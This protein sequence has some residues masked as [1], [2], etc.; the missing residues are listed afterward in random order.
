MPDTPQD[1][2]ASAPDSATNT[3]AGAHIDRIQQQLRTST[4]Q[5]PR[6]GLL[7]TLSP[8]TTYPE[9]YLK[10]RKIDRDEMKD[11]FGRRWLFQRNVDDL[12]AGLRGIKEFAEPL[13]LKALKAQLQVDLDVRSAELRLYV[14]SR[15]IFGIDR[16]ADHV[17]HMTLL[18]AA[19]H[20][21]DAAETEPTAFSEGSGVFTRDAEGAAQRHSMTVA[22]FVGLCRTLDLGAMY[23]AH[24][25]SVLTPLS[26]ARRATLQQ[27]TIARDKQ[28]FKLAALTGLLKGEISDH[29]YGLLLKVAEEAPGG[30]LYG[31]PVH[32][33]RLTLMGFRLQG[34]TLFSAIGEPGWAKNAVDRLSTPILRAV[35][36]WSNKI[37]FLPHQDLERF[38]LLQAFFANGPHGLSEAMARN[39]DHYQQSRPV[40]PLIVY[41]PDDPEHPLREY[42]S[43]TDFM[44]NLIGQLR[45]S[46][47][48]AFFSRFVAQRDKGT[49]FARVNERLK[50]FTWQHRE[51]LD[52][53]PWWRE[54]AT[55][56]PNPEPLTHI[57]RGDL[58][59]TLYNER[60]GKAISDA[61]KIAVP[62]GDEDARSRW[63][64]LTGYL[65]IAWNVFN[66]TAMLVPGLAE[67]MLAVMVAQLLE[68]LAEGL[69]DWSKGDREEAAAHISSVLINGAQLA[70]MGAGHVLPGATPVPI[71]ASPFFD[72][73]KEVQ[74]PDG[75]ASLWK[76]DL[77][78]YERPLP[79]RRDAKADAW[80]L[81]RQ[82][83]QSLVVLENKGYAVGQDPA[84]GQHRI[85]HPART[86]AYQPV[87]RHNGLGGWV[88][89][90]E[91]PLAWDESQVWRRVGHSIEQLSTQRQA[92][93]RI[94][95]GVDH[96]QLR[97]MHVEHEPPPGVLSDTLKRF[98]V[99]ADVE[100][101]SQQI[102]D[103][104]VG[105]SAEGFMPGFITELP[106]WP[107]SR[108]L[109]VFDHD[110]YTGA[111][112]QY[113]SLD[114]PEAS[115][116]KLSRGQ[117]H[118]GQWAER[119]LDALSEEEILGLLGQRVSSVRAERL[120]VLRARLAM[121]A[122]RQT[123]RVFNSIYRPTAAVSDRR[124]LLLQGDFPQ[125]PDP[126]AEQI[127]RQASPEDLAF[128]D[129]KSRVPLRLKAQA[130]E[131][132]HE[133]RVARAYEGLY[134]DALAGADT[135]RLAL[136]SVAALPGWSASVRIE[137]RE[138]SF[139]GSLRDS[140]GPAEAAIRRVLV[141]ND[142]GTFEA[143]D[144]LDQHLHGADD[145]Y[146]A[147]LH[148]L[149]D[150]ER[151]ALG[152][153]IA[154]KAQLK[155][156]V[157][158]QPLERSRFSGLLQDASIRKPA[159]D[160]QRIKLRGGMPFYR[161]S[162]GEANLRMRIQ[163]LYPAFENADID[164]VL[165]DL[166]RQNIPMENYVSSLEQEFSQLCKT[167][168]RWRDASP[169]ALRFSLPGIEQWQARDQFGTLL[170][171]CWQRTGPR[172]IEVPGQAHPQALIFDGLPLDRLLSNFPRLEANF[173][174]VTSL[175]MR[176]TGVISQHMRMLKLF[177]RLR[178]LDLANNLLTELPPQLSGM[179][180]LNDL[181]LQGNHITLVQESID[182]LRTLRHLHSLSLAGNPIG[183]VPDISLM[184]RLDVLVLTNT[185]IET[186]PLGLFS[187]PRPRNF[188]LDLRNNPISVV[189][190]VEP[191]SAQAE[192]L[193]RTH[194]T[195]Q[196][197]PMSAA[198]IERVREYTVS[199]GLDPDRAFPPLGTVESV[200]WTEGM[201]E[202]QWQ[203]LQPVWDDLEDEF[204]SEP[205]FS[206]LGDLRETADFRSGGAYREDLT[207]KVW[208]ML[209][210][211][212]ENSELRESLFA[213]ATVPTQCRDGSIQAFNEL[214][215]RVLVHEARSLVN[216][217]LVEAEL[218]ELAKG[219]SRIEQV[220]KI[221]RRH[222]ADRLAA[223]ERLRATDA[224]GNVTGTIDVVEVHLAFL[225]ALADSLDL[226]WQARSMLFRNIAGVT[227]QMIDDAYDTVL[228]LEQAPLLRQSIIDVPFW[229]DY[230]EASH[231][232]SFK[233]LRKRY[234]D[235]IA[236]KIA[237]D[238]RA[239]GRDLTPEA[240][241][242]LKEE[243]RVLAFE[244]GKPE[245]TIAPGLIM[246]EED[247]VAELAGV[248]AQINGLR[249]TLTQQAMDRAKIERVEMPFTVAAAP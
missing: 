207:N 25:N 78:P 160:P 136:H 108:A 213:E 142:N 62:T 24:I 33:Q 227:Q 124:Q 162:P 233:D 173:D 156:R 159:Y 219:Q 118:T 169:D 152:F 245:S 67:A 138:L 76:P 195:R 189:P 210:A 193:A 65:D 212:H 182:R 102:L 32:Q 125:L 35:L 22:Q 73:L 56:N 55:E 239:E 53:G 172:G 120:Q 241:D 246:S 214:G 13:L 117:L 96:N 126:F 232:R 131:A 135:E 243:L 94:V 130:R 244:L 40:G 164:R 178:F 16:G 154:H 194:L 134:L 201:S 170:R 23:Q 37:P 191:G 30:T 237:L 234:T 47:Y 140:V 68:E 175:R 176:H 97:R 137:V 63:K 171:R 249:E 149:P 123:E 181:A 29:G 54:T 92:Q 216:P 146:G 199:V 11:L 177:R 98:R 226:P 90:V 248:E 183:R 218:V 100:T 74:L 51:P 17:R 70:M 44:K 217:G 115:I 26:A 151:S 4:W 187:V 21:F 71:K 60:R 203:Q 205:F 122:G 107:E 127:L 198:A 8:I 1:K 128:V 79:L 200:H 12:T 165:D 106:R 41:I 103:N 206:L 231:R 110:S 197:P 163:S 143:R 225:V 133:V 86:N 141:L 15:I 166:Y 28:A 58:W 155:A 6:D 66:F 101:L 168:Q 89:E 157:Q 223:G 20:N 211:M 240:R 236:F 81:H 87:L 36:D 209:K 174:H 52:M 139:N 242:K 14:P 230:I 150:Q 105:E 43:F 18:D 72:S 50:T 208:R 179:P 119:V 34:I 145:V 38:K 184:S 112:I 222:V 82:D 148:A 220:N 192:L 49:F 196:E 88:S 221:A 158:Q 64:R 42:D 9:W 75:S 229:R 113:G 10:A 95:S 111:S 57:I 45:D 46:Q 19:L 3:S 99:Y 85:Q 180:F 114:A 147:L 80:G 116:I 185:Q 5:K 31:L 204:G 235:T 144:A 39:K 7:A 215:M 238:E 153:D 129:Q 83:G 59:V 247:Y 77:G 190:R 224:D 167:L 132:M 202:A 69:E 48:Q 186:W 228:T 121:H 188:Y 2:S 161:V 61:R 93:V 84:T 27:Q 104:Q 91:Q 109:Q